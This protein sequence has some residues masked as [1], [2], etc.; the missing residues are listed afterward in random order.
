LEDRVW[1]IEDLLVFEEGKKTDKTLAR[2]SVLNESNK[3]RRHK[4][5]PP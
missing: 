5:Q 3:E 2:L 1:G 4:M